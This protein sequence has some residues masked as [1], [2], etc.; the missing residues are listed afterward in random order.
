MQNPPSE[1]PCTLTDPSPRRAILTVV[2]K[3]HLDFASTLS[4]SCLTHESDCDLYIA[5]VDCLS[6]SDVDKTGFSEAIHWLTIAELQLPDWRRMAF[7]YTPFEFVCACKPFA[8]KV[9]RQRGCTEL[10]YIDADMW[11]FQPMEDVWEELK[12]FAILLTPHLVQP[13]PNDGKFPTETEYLRCGTF[14][15]GFVAI[16]GNA[17][18]DSMLDWWCNRMTSDCIVDIL[19][20]LFVDQ[21]WLNLVPGLF[22]A[23]QILRH[24]GY[25]AGHWSLSQSAIETASDGRFFI[26]NDPLVLFHFSKFLPDD[27]FSFERQQ[28][29]LKLKEIPSLKNLIAGYRKE[30]SQTRNKANQ[31]SGC[32]FEKLSCGTPIEPSWREAIR[33]RHISLEDIIDPFDSSSTP[34]LVARYRSLESESSEWRADWKQTSQKKSKWSRAW[35][36]LR[37]R[38]IDWWNHR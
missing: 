2:T 35:K 18:G 28:T 11:L 13:L 14:N 24:R 21:K 22:P 1:L 8:M 17:V 36:K 20:S 34:G 9:A 38:V 5:V 33:R 15:A 25:N 23:V 32:G 19:G 37:R 7:Q 3:S 26:G 16:K 29:R 12:T 4:R 27:P 6:A 10:V 31:N 30:L